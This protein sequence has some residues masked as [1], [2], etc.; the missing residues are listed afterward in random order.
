M[1]RLFFV[2]LL[3]ATLFAIAAEPA[4]AADN[5]KLTLEELIARHL[6]SIGKP[7]ARAANQSCGVDGAAKFMV[8]VGGA[9]Q[10]DGSLKLGSDGQK[11][12]MVMK[13]NT[14]SYMGEDFV[15]DGSKVYVASLVSSKTTLLGSF[16]F[17]RSSLL[18]EG[19]FGG[20]LTSGWLFLDPK[21]PQLK[22]K[23]NG[24]KK[25]EG[26]ELHELQYEP[27][28][29]AGDIRI[30]IYFEPDTYRHV[31]TI[32]DVR[33][34]NS[35]SQTVSVNARSSAGIVSEESRATLKEQFGEFQTADGLTVPT[36]WSITLSS[37]AREASEMRW[38]V[39]V[40][41]VA[42]VAIDPAVFKTR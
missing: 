42:H 14:P 3:L 27:R 28:K 36:V 11:L 40:Q 10:V 29:D 6:A 21:A 22:L 8:T 15:S 39:A 12:R 33:A 37:D 24:L 16:F 13:F 20:T 9:G 30:R 35:K 18:K 23:Y 26:R 1:R 38:N 34:V 5:P 41:S 2:L 19:L 17:P 7:E 31:L 4:I 25:V 32:Y